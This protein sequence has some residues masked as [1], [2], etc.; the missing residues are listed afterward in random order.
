M[1]NCDPAE[2]IL[3]VSQAFV[4]PFGIPEDPN[5]VDFMNYSN[6]TGL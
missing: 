6:R 1:T 2:V 5:C 4:F 3:H